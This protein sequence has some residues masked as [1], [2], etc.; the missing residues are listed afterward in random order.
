MSMADFWRA[1]S[2]GIEVAVSSRDSDQHLGVRDGFRRFFH[3][4]LRRDVSIVVKASLSQ[5][6]AAPL[7]SSEEQM[8][9]VA[10][11][12][13]LA[14]REGGASAPL[15]AVGLEEGMVSLEV[16]SEWHGFVRCRPRYQG[17]GGGAV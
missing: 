13:A 2:L 16:G 3:S 1:L 8:V 6:A 17:R 14:L 5:S 4:G 11:R 9:S 7:R 12:N 15:F 10:L